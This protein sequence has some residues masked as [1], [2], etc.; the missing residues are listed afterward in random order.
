MNLKKFLFLGLFASTLAFVGCE[1]KEDAC[2]K[3]CGEN[4]ILTIDCECV[5]KG[6]SSNEVKVTTNVDKNTTWTKDKIWILDARVTVLPGATLTI[7]PGTIVK[8]ATGTGANA[9]A[10]VVARGAKLN[11]E[12]TASAPIIFTTV[13]DEIQPGQIKSPNMDYDQ[14]GLW[15][16]LIILG[17]AKISAKGDAEAIQIEGIPASDSNGLY[18]GTDNADNSGVIKYISI[19]HGGANIGEGN[20]INGLTLGGVGSGTVIENVEVIANQDDG[21]ECFGGS[22]N[23]TNALVW[24]QGDDAYDMDQAYSG[25]IDNFIYIGGP[26]SD[27]GLE[28]DGAEGEAYNA[29]FTLKN[30]TLKGYHKDGEAAKGEYADLRDG[31]RCNLENMYF[32]NFKNSADLELDNNEV[33]QNYIDEHINFDNLQFNVS[34]KTEGNKTIEKIIIEKTK[35]GEEKLDCFGKRPLKD[36]VKVVTGKSTGADVSKFKGW[37]ATDL[38]GQLSEF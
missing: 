16:G 21:I 29:A 17:K 27:H 31:V 33:A 13:A 11:A 35:D 34:H 19:R 24:G 22:V 25:T 18:G 10:L 32:F 36:N 30:G 28:L 7:E 37:T 3:K 2:T 9:T 26:N 12:G 15:G 8:G 23:I 4:Q 20:E 5:D 6:T 38:D 1:E 14:D